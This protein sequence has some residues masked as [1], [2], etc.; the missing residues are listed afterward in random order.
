VKKKV[1]LI[2]CTAETEEMLKRI[3]FVQKNG[4]NYIMLDIL[5]LGWSALQTA[6][7]AI[8]CQFMHIEQGM[9]CLIETLNME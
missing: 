8:K 3:N 6:R 5:T 1:Y 4:G 9:Q 2:N 7:D